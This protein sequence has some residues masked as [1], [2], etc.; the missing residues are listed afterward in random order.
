MWEGRC[1]ELEFL[2][3]RADENIG[4]QM[5]KRK[6]KKSF[7]LYA[8][9]WWFAFDKDGKLKLPYLYKTRAINSDE[10]VKVRITIEEL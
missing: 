8:E 4:G 6:R 5:N 7:K 3:S 9:C 1:G 2:P 10:E